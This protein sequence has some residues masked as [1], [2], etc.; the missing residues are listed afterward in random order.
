M[1]LVSKQK[2]IKEN[3]EQAL[4]TLKDIRRKKLKQEEERVLEKMKVNG[5]KNDIFRLIIFS[6][7]WQIFNGK[8]E[9]IIKF[10][11]EDEGEKSLTDESF[12]AVVREANRLN[13]D[14]EKFCLIC[15]LTS[16]IQVGDLLIISPD[17]YEIKE[18]KTGK[19]NDVA[20]NLLKFYK[21]N[22]I[23]LD[24]E[25][26]GKSFDQK[27]INQLKRIKNQEERRERVKIGNYR[28]HRLHS[29]R[30]TVLVEYM[31]YMEAIRRLWLERSPIPTTTRA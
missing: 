11:I 21:H 5:Y 1:L 3:M 10:Y 30:M 14:S 23:E 6:V 17:G 22:A 15:D 13:G 31:E 26:M 8:R 7:V 27:F 28:L 4:D 24:N 16:N 20:S 25:R 9:Y 19:K 2:I 18:I 12:G 29:H